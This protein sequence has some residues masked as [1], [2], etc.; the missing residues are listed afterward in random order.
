MKFEKHMRTEHKVAH[1]FQYLLAGCA[2]SELERTAIKDVIKDRIELDANDGKEG[3]TTLEETS[4]AETDPLKPSPSF[5]G[6]PRFKCKICPISFTMEST[7]KDHIDKKHSKSES[8][9][10]GPE[11]NRDEALLKVI[12]NI[13]EN[14]ERSVK[15]T[16]SK[17]SKVMHSQLD[18][19]SDS[20]SEKQERF[21][22]KKILPRN[23]L[24]R[25]ELTSTAS[26]RTLKA[27]GQ[28]SAGG[29]Q[30]RT[31]GEAVVAG[32]GEEAGAGKI[33]RLCS[34]EFPSNGP[35]R[36]HFEDIHQPGEYP[37]KGCGKM[38]TSNNKMSSHYSRHCN[39]NRKQNR[40]TL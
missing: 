39:P 24:T 13:K 9:R 8:E 5:V 32:P 37:C 38:F 7:L 28:I 6:K 33:C 14:N 30:K 4:G 10:T 3:E 20:D 31:G 11:S 15:K 2:M 27:T 22:L 18:E 29:K 17:I 19:I 16:K 12:S 25:K 34:K 1:G 35:M 23:K 40:M 36:R 21:S 26:V